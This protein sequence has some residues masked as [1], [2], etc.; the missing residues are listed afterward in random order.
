MADPHSGH[1]LLHLDL[2]HN[3]V[4]GEYAREGHPRPAGQD[5]GTLTP[6]LPL[7]SPFQLLIIYVIC[8]LLLILSASLESWYCS[9]VSKELKADYKGF[10]HPYAHVWKPRFIAVTVSS[11]VVPPYFERTS[12]P[13]RSALSPLLG[14]LNS[15]SSRSSTGSWWRRTSS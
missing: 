8:C 13:R 12:H 7:K 1:P 4:H 11:A 9:K 3:Y 5:E 6:L 2:C 15:P 14:L 10:V